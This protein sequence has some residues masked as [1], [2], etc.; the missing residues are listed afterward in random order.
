LIL[1]ALLCA[2]SGAQVRKPVQRCLILATNDSESNFDGVRR[3]DGSYVGTISRIAAIKR[4]ELAKNPGGVLLVDAGDILQGRYM[5]R[6]DGDA[7]AARAHALELYRAAGYDV[8]TLGN[9]E[10]DAGAK[11]LEQALQ[12][13]AARPP[14]LSSNV[15][16]VQKGPEVAAAWQASL[17]ADGTVACGS[18]RLGLIGLLTPSAKTI[19]DFTGVTLHEPAT[20]AALAASQAGSQGAKVVVL[21][22]LGAQEDLQLAK[23]VAGIDVI[24]GG[25]SHTVLDKMVVVG[26]THIGQTGSRFANLAFWVLKEQDGR[27]DVQYHL[28]PI[29]EHMPIDAEVEAKV[30]DVRKTLISEVILGERKTTWDLM[31]VAH[32]TYVQLATRAVLEF[33]EKTTKRTVDGALLNLGGFRS[34]SV[35]PPG[36]VTNIEVQSIHPFKNR[37]VIVELTGEQLLDVL[38]NACTTGHSEQHGRN[39]AA[40]G[41]HFTCDE[42]KPVIEYEFRDNQPVA[43]R[44]H[45][46]RVTATVRGKPVDVRQIYTVATLDYLAKGGSNYFGLTLGKRMCLNLKPFAAMDGCPDS[47]IL[48]DVLTAALQD[49]SLERPL[50]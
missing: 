50:P 10:F 37:I 21:S 30:A 17:G 22:H 6:Q 15:D 13:A 11:V 14:V 42:R 49:G 44:R 16:R 36:P 8:I 4:R 9:H 38:E 45:G 24:I 47:A 3:P 26:T 2:C 29:D 31:D 33:A 40:T 32:S 28:E 18:L 25:H 39:L 20:I 27:L 35:Y 41:V 1:V 48:S 34:A 7:I 19:S 12:G 23:D 5:E 43:I 46:E